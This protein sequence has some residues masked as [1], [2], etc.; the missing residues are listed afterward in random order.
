MHSIDRRLASPFCA[1]WLCATL[2]LAPG[3]GVV[4]GQDGSDDTPPI[5]IPPVT[6]S[7]TV[8]LVQ[9]EVRVVDK[10]GN[11]ISGLGVEDFQISEDG[12]LQDLLYVDEHTP[13]KTAEPRKIP[14]R[15]L[16]PD[17]METE[18]ERPTAVTHSVIV[19]VDGANSGNAAISRQKKYLRGFVNN[20]SRPDTMVSVIELRAD[21][22]FQMLCDFTRD[23]ELALRALEKVKTGTGGG[24]DREMKYRMMESSFETKLSLCSSEVASRQAICRETAYERLLATSR[25][26]AQEERA[27]AENSIL[28]IQR[29]LRFAGH[30]PGRR[31]MILVS[32]GID[33]G[34]MSYFNTAA[35]LMQFF[36]QNFALRD[37]TRYI[38]EAQ[39]EAQMHTADLT[40]FQRINQAAMSSGVTLYWVNP[41]H[42]GEFTPFTPESSLG[43][44]TVGTDFVNVQDPVALMMDLARETGGIGLP[45]AAGVEGFYEQVA[46][47]LGS[48]YILSYTPIRPYQDGRKH[49]LDVKLVQ[50]RRGAKL[51]MREEFTDYTRKDRIMQ[52]LGSAL[53][54]PDV[55][56]NFPIQTA[57]SFLRADDKKYN[58]TLRIAIP[59]EE[60]VPL[61]N[62]DRVQDILHLA[63]AVRDKKKDDIL[64]TEHPVLNINQEYDR[65]AKLVRG[66]AYLDYRQQ[67]KLGPG[68]YE[69]TAV[70]FDETG[71]KSAAKRFIFS[72]PNLLTGCLSVTPLMLARTVTNVEKPEQ[73]VVF[74]QNGDAVYRDKKLSFSAVVTLPPAGT[75]AGLYQ[76]LSAA[77]GPDGRPSVEISFRLFKETAFINQTPPTRITRYNDRDNKI[78]TN[79]FAVPFSGLS[80]GSYRLELMAKD[81]VNGCVHR[82][83]TEFKV[84]RGAPPRLKEAD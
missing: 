31:S 69:I 70:V 9:I 39:R 78:I 17:V 74:D 44:Y 41:S 6:E 2:L 36:A 18:R 58:V 25:A 77:P 61:V 26:Y 5:V 43:T 76:I 45:R 59:Y 15:V 20:I 7:L 30:L 56:D 38:N 19:L 12:D 72:L 55:F 8:E 23:H 37:N 62:E 46:S 16:L 57:F 83:S 66:R 11:F 33:P 3:A 49:D 40:V 47:D 81:G 80:P 22:V 29:V 1:V 63:F 52:R 60:L 68:D 53:D 64:T 13:D 28:S 4:L 79:F 35:K 75:L 24:T 67:F 32:E 71:G 21:G 54:F 48:Y 65:Y 51:R 73:S 34:G 27:R 84:Q 10:K 82:A 42:Q 14:G 50:K